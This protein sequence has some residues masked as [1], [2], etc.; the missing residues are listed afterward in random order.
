MQSPLIKTRTTTLPLLILLAL[1]CLALPQRAHPVT[2]P[3]D[4]GYPGANTAEGQSALFSLTTGEFNTG[5]GFLSLRNNVTGSFNTAIGAAT[6]FGNTADQNTATGAGAL[7]SDNIGFQNTANG[8]FALFGNT[9]GS[10]NTA[11]GYS[12]L[13]SNSGD[14]NTGVGSGALSANSTGASNTAI[15][16]QALVNNATGM[17]NTAIGRTALGSNTATG[18]IAIGVGSG[19]GNGTGTGNIYISNG[20]VNGESNTIRIGDVQALTFIS[21]IGTTAVAGTAVVVNASGQLGVPSS[22]ATFKDDIKPMDKASEMILALQPV[23]FRYTKA[24]D[25]AGAPQFGLLAEEVEKVSPDLTVRDKKG[26][27]FTVRY[28]A[29]NAMLLNEFLKEHKKVQEEEALI[30]RLKSTVSK[31]QATIAQQCK[32]MEEVTARVREQAAQIE[33]VSARIDSDR[34]AQLMVLN[35]P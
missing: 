27:P 31:H 33:K 28:D 32:T 15:G 21:G 4:G 1:G 24:I 34:C 18:N 23:T 7:L 8:A 9:E 17:F 6:L 2:P 20:G 16:Y 14:S 35:N 22:S 5:V 26:K 19:S 30:Q 29:A 11:T 12:A 10:F 13:Y 3:P 25:P